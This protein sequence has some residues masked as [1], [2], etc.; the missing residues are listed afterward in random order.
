LSC[1]RASERRSEQ[2]RRSIESLVLS[3]EVERLL[4]RA[5]DEIDRGLAGDS[6][7]VIDEFLRLLPRASGDEVA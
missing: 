2:P 6:L 1:R 5:Q 7:D 4:E 3:G